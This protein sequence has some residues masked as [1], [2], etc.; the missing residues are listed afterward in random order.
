[1]RKEENLNR[2]QNG[3]ATLLE[4]LGPDGLSVANP[5]GA[6]GLRSFRGWPILEQL[7]SRGAEADL[8]IVQAGQERQVLKLYRH[9]LEPKLEVM[10]RIADLSRLDSRFIVFFAEAGFD[11]RT[12][13]WYE[14]LE[15]MPLGS[16]S[17]VSQAVKQDPAFIK[18]LVH[19]LSEAIQCLHKI[20]I[21]H[22]DIKPPNVLI[23]SLDPPDLVLT[24]FGISS[25]LASDAS[26]KM[27]ILKGTPMYWAPEA[28]SRMVGRPSD[29]W[30]LGMIVLE[31]LAGRHPFEGLTDSQIIR[32]LTIG[33]VEVSN[34]IDP[35]WAL[36]VKG[37]LTKDDGRRWGYEEVSK[38]LA[39]SRDI[40]AHYDAPSRK[41]PFRFKGKEFLTPREL[42]NAFAESETP[43]ASAGNYLR[44]IRHWLGN[45]AITDEADQNAELAL[46][47]FVY[48]NAKSPFRLLGKLIDVDNLITIL[49]R[50]ADGLAG[51][52]EKQVA[53]MLADGQCIA[54]YDEYV[55][56][57]G[58]ERDPFLYSLLN[59]M[60]K[61]E[62]REQLG[63]LNVIR[64]PEAYFWP[65]DANCANGGGA[66]STE[67]I[68][69]LRK[70]GAVPLKRADWETLNNGFALPGAFLA[71]LSRADTY[72]KGAEKLSRWKAEGLLM[73]RDYHSIEYE[74]LSLT[75]YART[76]R[77]RCLGHTQAA[78]QRIDSLINALLSVSTPQNSR[79]ASNLLF[80]VER[81]R[82]LKRVKINAEDNLFM[83]KIENLL[84]VRNRMESRRFAKYFA[85]GGLGGLLFFAARLAAGSANYS[86]ITICAV[87]LTAAML[88]S[89]IKLSRGGDMHDL[90]RQIADACASYLSQ[91]AE[92]SY[93]R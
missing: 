22:C 54:F 79:D 13:R 44:Y 38:W 48:S 34:S 3:D 7:P 42:A 84:E 23:R 16:L 18:N 67:V 83:S 21:V 41:P 25:V 9:R 74:R 62:L 8:Y 77:V 29:W 60:G 50:V 56:L 43:W 69:A 75:E 65:E 35:G 20:D 85:A 52:A 64:D 2:T 30:G 19:E 63:Y 27:T 91:T 12:G 31:L 51:G 40:P 86:F 57:S 73:P 80:C 39:G 61:K 81:L 66:S 76:A 71:K 45:N 82:R 33:N 93:G 89:G 32:K 6:F 46:S 24:D 36:L 49:S 92:N 87:V 11:E 26:K 70:I 4:Q 53:D 72:A 78:L 90:F 10:T 55:K 28:F 37:L 47:R 5:G 88:V 17:D 59:F 58:F 1:M 15:Y 68:D 14:L